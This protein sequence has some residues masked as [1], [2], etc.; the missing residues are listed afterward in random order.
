MHASQS[1]FTA[2]VKIQSLKRQYRNSQDR[3]NFHDPVPSTVTNDIVKRQP[4][5]A[6]LHL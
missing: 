5:K 3:Y 2:N 6:L 4:L 1:V